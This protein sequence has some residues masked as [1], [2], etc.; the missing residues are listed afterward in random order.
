ML[1]LQTDRPVVITVVS[2]MPIQ[3]HS[4][5]SETV[6][7]RSLRSSRVT[8]RVLNRPW[9]V[10][11]TVPSSPGIRSRRK[12]ACSVTKEQAMPMPPS[13][14]AAAN[15]AAAVGTGPSS[16]QSAREPSQAFGSRPKDWA[17]Q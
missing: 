9:V 5:G 12:W 4:S 10:R 17:V 13:S 8:W 15:A 2:A 11:S 16:S 7:P 6:T 14:T 1:L 3:R